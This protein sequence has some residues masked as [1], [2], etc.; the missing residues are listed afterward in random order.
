MPKTQTVS[1][2]RYTHFQS[3]NI[4]L[5][6]SPWGFGGTDNLAQ[7]GAHALLTEQEI[8]KRLEAIGQHAHEIL[9]PSLGPFE[10]QESRKHIRNCDAILTVNNW[11]ADTVQASLKNGNIPLTLGGDA[12][13]SI[14]SIHGAREFY[15]EKYSDN[16]AIIWINN[17]LCNSSPEVTKS[18]NAN[19]MTYTALT[20][21]DPGPYGCFASLVQFRNS[22]S[23]VLNKSNIVHIGVN[24]R[25]AQDFDEHKF[26]TMQ[27]IDELGARPVIREAI[28]YLD[29]FEHIHI[30]W[31]V[32]SLDL[33]GV[34]NYSLGQ[35]NYREALTIA[36]EIDVLLRRSGKLK[37]FDIVEHCP[38]REAWDKKG[39]T[40]E[41]MTD[42]VCNIFGENI[43]NAARR[44]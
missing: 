35:L 21:A 13:L 44:Y 4:D 43:F 26:Y 6:V 32:N 42:I 5:I 37:S 22:P 36:R 27:D 7:E 2:Q 3:P 9:P 12:S 24:H 17:H 14:G 28:D 1:Q 19:R 41:W 34:S 11:L 23:P 30:I 29:K 18:W 33:S 39:E 31:D 20:Q 40:A 25:S 15:G 16:L 8:V 38:S 10:V